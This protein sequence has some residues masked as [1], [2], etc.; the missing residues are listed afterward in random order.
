MGSIDWRDLKTRNIIDKGNHY[1]TSDGKTII[2]SSY[3]APHAQRWLAKYAHKPK[4]IITKDE[5]E[6]C[7]Y[8]GQIPENVPKSYREKL[9]KRWK[10]ENGEIHAES[11]FHKTLD[12][13]T[14]NH[15][16]NNMFKIPEWDI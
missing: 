13:S 1:E 4:H 16:P 11:G 3:D 8:F 15:H 9:V 2:W 14:K 6:A 5:R 10:E 7:H 12:G